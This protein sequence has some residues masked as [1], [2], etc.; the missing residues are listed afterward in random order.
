MHAI[1]SRQNNFVK[2]TSYCCRG[3]HVWSLTLSPCESHPLETCLSN[4][5]LCL[6][7]GF[8]AALCLLCGSLALID[9]RRG[10]IPDALQSRNRRPRPG[11]GRRRGRRARRSRGHRRSA[12]RRGHLLAVSASLFRRAENPGA[13]AGRRQI[14]RGRHA[15]G[16]HCR[17]SHAASDRRVVGAARDRRR[18]TRRAEADPPDFAAV[19]SLSGVGLLLT[20]AAQQWLGLR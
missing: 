9:V 12:R 5:K 6:P 19:R 20:L 18:A 16:R 11:Q 4:R 14:S 2:Q 8:F 17:H 1:L 3:R 7:A 15:M 13:W 10:I